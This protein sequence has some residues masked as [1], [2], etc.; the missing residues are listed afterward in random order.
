[1]LA[2]DVSPVIND[3]VRQMSIA[4]QLDFDLVK[5][6]MAIFGFNID[7]AELVAQKFFVIVGV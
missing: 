5:L 1:L 2:I 7:N 6:F 4:G 3:T